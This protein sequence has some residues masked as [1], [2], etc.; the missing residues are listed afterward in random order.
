[1]NSFTQLKPNL[2]FSF[3]F[4]PLVLLITQKIDRGNAIPW[5]GDSN[6]TYFHQVKRL[7]AC[8]NQVRL[9]Q[10]ACLFQSYGL[11]GQLANTKNLC[12]SNHSLYPFDSVAFYGNHCHVVSGSEIQP[13]HSC[14][15]GLPSSS[16]NS[17]S[18]VQWQHFSMSLLVFRKKPL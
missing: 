8:T 15:Q 13:L 5:Y 14:P 17:G 7:H 6:Q 9:Q 4:F 10:N 12:R 2:S 1:M 16:L 11:H 18:L 3:L